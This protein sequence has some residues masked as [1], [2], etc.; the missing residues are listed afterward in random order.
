MTALQELL[1]APK[2]NPYEKLSEKAEKILRGEEFYGSLV[3]YTVII[4]LA[5]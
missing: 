2:D 4:A 5:V 3:M 1:K